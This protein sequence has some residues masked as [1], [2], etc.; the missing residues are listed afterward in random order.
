MKFSLDLSYEEDFIM[1]IESKLKE[2][3]RELPPP[4]QKQFP[5][6]PGVIIGNLAFMSGH[7]PTVNG[8]LP[9][10][11]IVGSNISIE[12]AQE[13]AIICTLNLFSALKR[14]L[15]D[16]NRVK[17]IVKMTGFVASTPDFF[18][19]TA[20][21]N[22]ASHFINDIFGPELRHS[23]SAIGVASLPGGAPVEIEL[24]VEID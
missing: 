8:T 15:G 3:N 11:G 12:Q 14:V 22:A 20:V 13:C 17:R 21:I 16:L 23:R 24:I 18:D 10:K 6:D 1:D 4:S 19:Q 2:L 5:F 7:T 9:Y